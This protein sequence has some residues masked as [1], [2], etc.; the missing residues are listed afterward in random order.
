MTVPY[1]RIPWTVHLRTPNAG[2]GSRM[3]LGGPGAFAWRVFV[4]GFHPSGDVEVGL[5]IRENIPLGAE[6]SYFE[7]QH[8][9]VL[10]MRVTIDDVEGRDNQQ[11]ANLTVRNDFIP[12]GGSGRIYSWSCSWSWTGHVH[13]DFVLEIGEDDRKIQLQND[14]IKLQDDITRL[15]QELEEVKGDLVCEESR[16]ASLLGMVVTEQLKRE[17]SDKTILAMKDTAAR[18]AEQARVRV[19]KDYTC[20][21]A[22]FAVLLRMVGMV[23]TGL[24]RRTCALRSS[25]RQKS[26]LGR[27][28]RLRFGQNSLGEC[29][30]SHDYFPLLCQ[31]PLRQFS[32]ER[33]LLQLV[34]QET[35]GHVV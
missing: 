9:P 23:R 24:T 20:T 34:E 17:E 29:S 3:L 18:L 13:L 21:L 25:P 10:Q 12:N 16:T 14:A 35:Q 5:E 30:C 22:C 32:R 7:Q 1:S 6:P 19:A 11:S 8:P 15:Q 31:P 26:P 27:S 4:A 33:C 28:L 2:V